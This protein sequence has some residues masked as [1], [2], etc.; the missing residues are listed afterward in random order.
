[1]VQI[2]TEGKTDSGMHD[3]EYCEIKQLG[4]R[5]RSDLVR[6]WHERNADES[7]DDIELTAQI[8][9]S[10]LLLDTLVR[11]GTVPSWPLF[12][13][14]ILQAKSFA[15]DEAASYGSYGHLYQALMTKHMTATSKRKDSLGLKYTYLSMVA[16]EMFDQ[17]K[18]ALN[19]SEIERYPCSLRERIQGARRCRRASLRN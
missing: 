10:E 11:N 17:E 6:K 14:S 2:L 15:T 5:L 16:Y 18:K 9:A 19:E 12:I 4:F 3:V 13:L 1:M 8:S 7:F